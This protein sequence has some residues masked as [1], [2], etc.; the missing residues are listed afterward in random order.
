MHDTIHTNRA[1]HD[2]AKRC[3]RHD[4]PLVKNNNAFNIKN[5]IITTHSLQGRNSYATLS[6]PTL[7]KQTMLIINFIYMG[8]FITTNVLI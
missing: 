8:T 4:I 2:F 3:I 1:K 5:K 6:F 7:Q